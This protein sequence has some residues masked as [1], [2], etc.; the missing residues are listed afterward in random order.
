MER[1]RN[2]GVG[3]WSSSSNNN[4][5]SNGHSSSSTPGIGVP[6]PPSHSGM[7]SPDSVSMVSTPTRD[8]RRSLESL[9]TRVSG[10]STQTGAQKTA[11]ANEEEEVN[12]EVCGNVLP[13]PS[14]SCCFLDREG[15]CKW[16]DA[17]VWIV[18]PECHPPIPGEQ[19][20]ETQSRQGIISHLEVHTP[21]TEEAECQVAHLVPFTCMDVPKCI[22]HVYYI[23][24]S[25]PSMV[26][27]WFGDTDD[28]CQVKNSC[29]HATVCGCW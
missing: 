22:M 17:D 24:S 25:P 27:W 2:P 3:Y 7:T 15:R 23:I 6:P 9:D 1:S 16:M 18:S 10:A 13:N 8:S 12:L 21:G 29:G 5:T 4:N 26:V 28:C 20:D 11:P 19:G 14:C